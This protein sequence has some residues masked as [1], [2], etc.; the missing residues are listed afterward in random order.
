MKSRYL[1]GKHKFFYNIISEFTVLCI[2]QYFV[3]ICIIST[4]RMEAVLVPA[5]FCPLKSF[6]FPKREFGSK[7]EKRS[8]RAEWCQQFQWLHYYVGKDQRS[9]ICV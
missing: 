1:L 8:F 5:Q 2:T 3:L 9:G 6:N 4:W 7:G